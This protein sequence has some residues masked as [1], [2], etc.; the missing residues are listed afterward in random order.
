MGKA[1]FGSGGCHRHILKLCIVE[2]SVGNRSEYGVI[3]QAFLD[4]TQP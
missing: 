3:N 4:A 2:S 1:G